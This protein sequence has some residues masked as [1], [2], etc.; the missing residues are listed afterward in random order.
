MRYRIRR[1]VPPVNR[2]IVLVLRGGGP[3]VRLNAVPWRVAVCEPRNGMPP[4]L[5]CLDLVVRE[6][7]EHTWFIVVFG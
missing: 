4:S 1:V 7:C 5:R 6:A 3:F 2:E